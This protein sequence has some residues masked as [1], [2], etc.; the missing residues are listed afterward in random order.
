MIMPVLCEN[1]PLLCKVITVLCEIIHVFCEEL[2]ALCDIIPMLCDVVPVLHVSLCE[3]K[4]VLCENYTCVLALQPRHTHS[5]VQF[6]AEEAATISGRGAGVGVAVAC[7]WSG[8]DSEY[9][10][11]EQADKATN[12]Q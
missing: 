5:P 1:I 8:V 10:R 2:L 4:P 9:R 11:L 12:P 7:R 3:V 6:Y